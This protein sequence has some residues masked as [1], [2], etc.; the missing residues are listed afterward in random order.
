MLIPV[1]AVHIPE[2]RLRK[3]KAD[4]AALYARQID[5]GRVLPPV[6][7]RRTPNGV[8]A[9]AL[10]SGAHRLAAHAGRESIEALVIEA[11]AATA[12]TE[13]IEENLFRNELTALERIDAVA[14]WR[15]LFEAR[16]GR[17]SAGNPEFSNRA[18][19]AQL[20]GLGLNEDSQQGHFFDRVKERLGLTRRSV[21]RFCTIAKG[22]TPA[23]HDV[24]EGSPLEDNQALIE[25]LS[26][27]EPGEQAK[28][29]QA[30]EAHGFDIAAGD[31]AFN[32]AAKMSRDERAYEGMADSWTR[33]N[34][35]V[36]AK[37]VADFLPGIGA[38]IVAN[39]ALM[40]A[41]IGQFGAEIKAALLTSEG[42][43]S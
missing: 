25:R 35:K 27:L 41:F 10:V 32:P 23:L 43:K 4:Y 28:Y 24:L 13:E 14:A 30:L 17:I 7:V 1:S 3:V 39:P 18:N 40:T 33:T 2:G 9:Y 31:A 12:Q 19:L 34:A 6:K 11:D 22:L 16:Y 36:R 20:D 21:Q 15:D 42:V 38:E 37:F 5:E 26:R 29:A 8:T